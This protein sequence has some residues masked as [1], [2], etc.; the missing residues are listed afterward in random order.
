[1]ARSWLLS[2]E[3]SRALVVLANTPHGA[4]TAL[5]LGYG[6]TRKTITALVRAGLATAIPDQVVRADGRVIDVSRVEITKTGQRAV[7][8]VDLPMSLYRWNPSAPPRRPGGSAAKEFKVPDP[9]KLIAV[10]R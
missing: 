8:T 10:R 9:R 5:L 2:A 7:A 4:T 1:M 6:F 3:E